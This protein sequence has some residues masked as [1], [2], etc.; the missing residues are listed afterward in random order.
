[1]KDD[2]EAEPEADQTEHVIAALEAAVARKDVAAMAA[3][4]A[5]DATL[6]SYL[7]TRVFARADGVCHGR[8]EIEQLART[9]MQG[10]PPWGSHAPPIIR[11]HTA[12]IEYKTRT[13]EKET[14]SVDII[15]VR[16]GKIQSLRAYAGWRA[17][18]AATGGG[19]G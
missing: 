7:V 10:P 19:R 11:G 14:F 12:A 13:S 18:A 15:E 3:L 6:E 1:M 2:R 17:L 9:L 4:F 5:E 8:A 16:H